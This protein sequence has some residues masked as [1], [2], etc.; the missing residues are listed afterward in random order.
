MPLLVQLDRLCIVYP[1]TDYMF[2]LEVESHFK[3]W[4]PKG[5]KLKECDQWYSV[6]QNNLSLPGI[7]AQ[8]L[9]QVEQN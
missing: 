9:L 6:F 3:I 5:R 8:A 7:V 1:L 2:L 4:A